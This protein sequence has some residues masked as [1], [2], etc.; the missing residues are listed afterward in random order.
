MCS[1]ECSGDLHDA[2]SHTPC[3]LRGVLCACH[4]HYIPGVGCWRCAL[5]PWSAP[6]RLEQSRHSWGGQVMWGTAMQRGNSYSSITPSCSYRSFLLPFTILSLT[7][8]NTI[9][10]ITHSFISLAHS[11]PHPCTH[12]PYPYLLTCSLIALTFLAHST[13]PWVAGILTCSH[14]HWR[15]GLGIWGDMGGMG[16]GP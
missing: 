5:Y 1:Q 9:L 16:Y 13:P 14:H 3:S 4:T 11:A 10:H 2:Y 8:L 12:T 7:L 6:R 15:G